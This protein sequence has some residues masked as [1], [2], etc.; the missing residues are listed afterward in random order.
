MRGEPYQHQAV[1]DRDLPPFP[2]SESFNFTLYKDTN[3]SLFYQGKTLGDGAVEA[4][5]KGQCEK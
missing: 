1:R 5:M 4:L 2:L 3:L